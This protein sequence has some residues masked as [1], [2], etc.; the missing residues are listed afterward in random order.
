M[1]LRG[2]CRGEVVMR[3]LAG[4]ERT[5]RAQRRDRQTADTGKDGTDTKIQQQS[6][7][8][9][10]LYILLR[11]RGKL[12]SIRWRVGLWQRDSWYELK[13][14]TLMWTTSQEDD[15]NRGNWDTLPKA[16]VTIATQG[17]KA[18]LI[19]KLGSAPPSSPP[20]WHI[21]WKATSNPLRQGTSSG[22][23]QSWKWKNWAKNY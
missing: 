13:G 5:A 20:S 19:V 23:K 17:E 14:R 10:L 3:E 4:S 9:E 11:R 1:A 8:V 7:R 2:N 18:L 22:I 16:E 12:Y 21:V 15:P 6:G